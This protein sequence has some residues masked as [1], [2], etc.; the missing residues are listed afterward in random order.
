MTL[1]FFEPER[2]PA[3]ST[4]IVLIS[5]VIKTLAGRRQTSYV[6][7][8]FKVAL[9]STE[10]T[11]YKVHISYDTEFFFKSILNELSEKKLIKNLCKGKIA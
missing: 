11:S 9:Y 10:R 4:D 7:L 6:H 1:N 5:S 8:D 3:S 2:A